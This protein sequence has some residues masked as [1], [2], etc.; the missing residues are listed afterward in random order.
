[1]ITFAN[2][3]LALFIFLLVLGVIVFIHELGHF[4]AA[5]KSGVVVQEFAFGFGPR[6]WG[7]KWKGTDYKINLY[8]VGGYCKMLGDQ[9]GSSFLRYTA[10]EYDKSDKD[11]ALSKLK[12]RGLNPKT[13]SY[14]QV[15][16]YVNELKESL[17]EEDYKKVQNYIV[18]DYI[19]A[20]PGNFENVSKK[21][22]A[23]IV[24]A[25]VVMNFI[26]GVVL[27]YIFFA[28][29]GFYVDVPKIGNPSFIGAE[30]GN[31]PF[32]ETL[33]N[34]DNTLTNSLVI[35]AEDDLITN[36]S[37]FKQLLREKYNQPVDLLVQRITPEG[38]DFK[39]FSQILNG[40]G[41]ASVFD[42]DLYL[43]PII[44]SVKE[45]SVA[46]DLGLVPGDI[47]LSLES[48]DV[49]GFPEL[50]KVLTE[51]QG[52]SISFTI[53]SNNEVKEIDFT[54]PEVA[55]GEK[56]LLGVTYYPNDP[57]PSYLLRINYLNNKPLSG[58]VHAVNMTSYNISGLLELFR[59]SI[60]QGS[61]EPVASSVSSIVGVSKVVYT[62]VEVR[63]FTNILN[64]AALISLSLAV[65][66]L[67]PIPL[68]DG[69][70]LVFLVLE[71]VR[72]RKLST[73]TQEKIS[74]IAFYSLIALSV[75]IIFKD[76]L[77]FNFIQEIISKIS[78]I[79][80]P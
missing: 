54:I 45:D 48:Q 29:T 42:E 22:R 44:S 27:Y 68:F 79:F 11:F 2:I 57:F 14:S 39:E 28:I 20:H 76:I 73:S 13:S 32:Y 21:K 38:Y 6:L 49:R 9:D 8:P 17:S 46:E 63:D 35:K 30:V 56:V 31:I 34:S 12:E 51:R 78:S 61:V 1:M 18:Y 36:A 71:K 55:D 62:L 15:E 26:L 53:L 72:G 67:L 70:H 24:S 33:G 50:S 4:I 10:K 5:K 25:G 16:A 69:G 43:A 66:N 52:Q 75:V 37:Q 41:Y 3:A 60:D 19:P 59:Q 80:N 40:D 65:M 23:I 74:I 47:L 77:S 58:L 7:Y 64:L